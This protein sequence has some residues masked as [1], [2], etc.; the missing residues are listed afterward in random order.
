VLSK[1][2][3]FAIGKGSPC[4]ITVA[5]EG[6]LIVQK[7]IVIRVTAITTTPMVRI[8]TQDGRVFMGVLN[9]LFKL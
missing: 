8:G 9:F 5:D 7:L 6:D 2:V 4:A 1:A 3:R